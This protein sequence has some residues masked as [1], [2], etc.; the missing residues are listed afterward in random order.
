[1]MPTI[2]RTS[3]RR[4]SVR[5]AKQAI[6]EEEQALSAAERA[7]ETLL[8]RV[9][10]CPEAGYDGRW[11]M[12]H[13]DLVPEMTMTISIRGAMVSTSP[14]DA[15]REAIVALGADPGDRGALGVLWAVQMATSLVL[16]GNGPNGR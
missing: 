13:M 8:R 15:A 12:E 5:A 9:R 16:G 7:Y 14:R 11:V 1:M 4:E 10:S 3:E 2:E 6:K